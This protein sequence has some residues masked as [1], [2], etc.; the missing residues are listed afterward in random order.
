MV[1]S[2]L[3][4]SE[5]EFIHLAHLISGVSKPAMLEARHITTTRGS[6]QH[7]GASPSL[8]PSAPP[9]KSILS[10]HSTVSL[11]QEIWQSLL[12]LIMLLTEHESKWK[13]SW[14]VFKYSAALNLYQYF[15]PNGWA[16]LFQ[17]L[18]IRGVRVKGQVNNGLDQVTKGRRSKSLRRD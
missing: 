5:T 13:L 1:R 17:F 2:G 11:M 9:P 18:A 6:S 8:V 7:Q 12:D 15:S 4:T 10:L 16:A 14:T 3:W